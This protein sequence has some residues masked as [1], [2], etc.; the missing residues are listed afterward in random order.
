MLSPSEI[1]WNTFKIRTCTG[2]S[3]HLSRTLFQTFSEY[4]PMKFLILTLYGA[5]RSRIRQRTDRKDRGGI[6]ALR[7]SFSR[8][9]WNRAEKRDQS[10]FGC[11]RMIILTTLKFLQVVLP[12]GSVQVFYMFLWNSMSLLLYQ[13]LHLLR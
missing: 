8:R 4:K 12:L 2:K 10:S 11:L 5:L 3:V 6:R 13:A 1:R 9:G 7:R